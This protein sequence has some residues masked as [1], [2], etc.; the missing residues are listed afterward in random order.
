M[1]R[2]VSDPQLPRHTLTDDGLAIG[3]G[4][5]SVTRTHR[6]TRKTRACDV[7]VPETMIPPA[8]AGQDIRCQRDTPLHPGRHRAKRY[9]HHHGEIQWEW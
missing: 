9:N 8:W 7:P 1:H 5:G 3:I 6:K 2:F 4:W